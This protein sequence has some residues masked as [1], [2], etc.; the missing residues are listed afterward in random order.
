MSWLITISGSEGAGKTTLV[1]SLEEIFRS[2]GKSVKVVNVRLGFTPLIV[3]IKK[4]AGVHETNLSS[5]DASSTSG[6][7]DRESENFSKQATWQIYRLLSLLELVAHLVGIRVQCFFGK[8]L[9][10][11]RYLWDNQI[12]Y[13]EK[14]GKPDRVAEILWSAAQAAARVPDAA[15]F[16]NIPPEE[17]Y[18][19]V[20]ERN[21]GREEESLEV[22]ERRA[23]MYDALDQPGLIIID[24]LKS[25]DKVVDLVREE[26]EDRDVIES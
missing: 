16:L 11:N 22:L 21:M 17:S 12:I 9:I 3:L 19:R 18:R 20:L 8:R 15:F 5:V 24:G 26:L 23:R 4:A 1:N 2:S 14:Y 25:P 10:A 13:R 7:S 6:S